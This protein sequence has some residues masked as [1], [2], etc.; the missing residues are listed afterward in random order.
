MLSI[1]D[2][3]P[4]YPVFEE[5]KEFQQNIY[6]RY[7]FR[8]LDA[9]SHLLPTQQLAARYF[10]PNTPYNEGL[11]IHSVGTGKSCLAYACLQPS[12]IRRKFVIAKGQDSLVNLMR[13]FAFVC[14]PALGQRVV[15]DRRY[16]DPRENGKIRLL[17]QKQGVVFNTFEVF[18]KQLVL[19]SDQ[20]LETGY[21][22]S[23]F[24]IDEVHNIPQDSTTY[25]QLHRLF[26]IT[27]NRKVLLLTATPM[28]DEVV[29]IASVMNLLLPLTQQL[30]VG[31]EFRNRFIDGTNITHTTELRS[32][33]A[34]RVSV[35]QPAT[36]VVQVV[37]D[38]VQ[39][40]QLPADIPQFR[41]VYIEMSELQ[42]AVFTEAYEAE[43]SDIYINSRK[44]SLFVPPPAGTHLD[45]ISEIQEYSAK[46]AAAI[47]DIL[48][49][50]RQ[51]I[52]VYCSLVEKVGAKKF[53]GL[54]HSF[55]YKRCR[56]FEPLPD[57]RYILLTNETSNI[58]A[59]LNYY[60]AQ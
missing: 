2:F 15:G 26:H 47:G 54:L 10:S 31:N 3:T 58:N 29:E 11:I 32:A 7:E 50:P 17:L 30:P 38:G 35:Y 36:K 24:I 14:D 20:Q 1:K 37:Y 22:D 8:H 12:A 28:R 57:K 4:S 33:F 53:A 18:A 23:I 56:G 25:T 46:F 44:A 43:K 60:N 49:H 41:L 40:K 59:L 13:A 55:G 45:K 48:K 27:R 52:F 19:L 5:N 6:D 21:S 39:P 51:N 16:A 42:T 34:G 9:S